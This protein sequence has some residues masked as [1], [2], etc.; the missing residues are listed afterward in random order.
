MLLLA[1]CSARSA[2]RCRRPIKFG[3]VAVAILAGLLLAFDPVVARAA[4]P[5]DAGP[6]QRFELG[7]V[8]AV[9]EGPRAATTLTL[10]QP[11]YVVTLTTYHWNKGLGRRPGSMSIADAAGK[12]VAT[13]NARG[14]PGFG[15][16]PNAYWEA[17][18]ER[19]LE[20]GT[21]TIT[22]NSNNTWS[23]N[24]GTGWAGFYAIEYQAL[25]V[26][27]PE[28]ER[29]DQAFKAFTKGMESFE[30]FETN[31]N[32][33]TWKAGM[34]AAQQAITL[35][36]DT[37]D[38]WRLVGYGYSLGA[39]QSE[40]G[41]AYA[42]E[43]FSKA[44]ELDP[45]NAGA[46]MLLAGVLIR[47]EAWSMAMDQVEAALSIKPE[48]ATTAVIAD[49]TGMYLADA[50]A[51]RGID[52]LNGFLKANRRAVSARLGLAILY[53][54]NGDRGQARSLAEAVALDPNAPRED[55]EHAKAL[56]NTLK[57]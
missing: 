26:V 8:D 30:A 52:F 6:V 9:T 25:P 22:T 56:L 42:E 50:Q 13:V 35:Q 41:S 29:R 34:E 33:D 7:N 15:G 51:A 17:K 4:A 53:K 43:A 19:R 49:L 21:Y 47:R 5:A 48:L 11:I 3:W 31:R 45:N 27:D 14:K 12:V 46:R 37:A 28:T 2:M 10:E 55:A 23:T 54:E 20:P 44:I 18:I 24:A 32:P 36:P 40:L 1:F 57:E 16:V 39:D 38:Y